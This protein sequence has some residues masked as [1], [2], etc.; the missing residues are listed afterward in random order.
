[1]M[2]DVLPEVE[3]WT[4]SGEKVALATVVSVV[5]SAPRAVG[6]TLAVSENGEIAG[7]VS[8]GCV[9]PAV[10]EQ[11]MRAIRT[12]RPALLQFGITEEQNVEQIGLSCGGEIRVFV[13]RLGD[14]APLARSIHAEQPVVQ[15]TVITAPPGRDDLLGAQISRATAATSPACS[16]MRH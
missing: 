9:E 1:M 15:A 10:I 14:A 13:E 7:S 12:G 4:A 5:G 11:G 2:R 3:R 6:A 16:A 8:G